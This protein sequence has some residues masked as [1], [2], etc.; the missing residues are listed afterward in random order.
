MKKIINFL[1]GKHSVITLV[2]ILFIL[3]ILLIASL[4]A[5]QVLQ[6]LIEKHLFEIV[7]LTTLVE[8][9]LLLS[10]S[11]WRVTPLAIGSEEEAQEKVRYLLKEDTAIKSINVLSAGL[12]SRSSFLRELIESHRK[13][14]IEI[15]TCFSERSPNP[16]PRDREKL[17]PAMYYK[18]IH[19]LELDVPDVESRLKIYRSHNTPSFRCILL[20]DSR[21]PRYGIVGWYTYYDRNTKIAGRR[22]IQIF[23]DRT[24]ETGVALLHFAEKKFQE[25]TSNQE[26]EILW[27]TRK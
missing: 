25:Y 8:V 17:G 5:P 10:T 21:G 6:F 20:A 15:I 7:V 19:D 24:T 18:I 12:S 26:A 1:I 16:D 4:I 11:L 14:K 22:N 3:D 13:Y 23:V 2:T 27:P 9:L